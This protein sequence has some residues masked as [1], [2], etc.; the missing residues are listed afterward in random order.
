MLQ[1]I[2]YSFRAPGVVTGTT[3]N[4]VLG[5]ITVP[6]TMH[7]FM[8]RLEA[9]SGAI[10][11]DDSYGIAWQKTTGTP[12]GGDDVVLAPVN[13]QHPVFVAGLT[14]V[15]KFDLGTAITG[16]TLTGSIFAI[17]HGNKMDV[18]V[19]QASDEAEY[20]KF[21]VGERWACILIRQPTASLTLTIAGSFGLI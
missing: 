16:L 14:G 8:K 2:A 18:P 12:S 3:A 11:S 5:Y 4:K 21:G 6:A 9:Y 17:A 13:N 10:A 20:A 7:A 1:D 15:F 19:W